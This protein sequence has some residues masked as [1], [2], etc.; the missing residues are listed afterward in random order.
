MRRLHAQLFVM[1]LLAKA[2][3]AQTREA[4]VVRPGDSALRVSH[5]SVMG[6]HLGA[7][8]AMLHAWMTELMAWYAAGGIAP[9]ID[10]TFALSQAAAAHQYIHDRRNLGKVLLIP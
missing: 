5:T 1:L 10:R 4:I 8:P 2:V 3:A 9:R 6:S 7:P